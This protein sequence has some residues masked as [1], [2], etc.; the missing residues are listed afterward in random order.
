M[1]YI[2]QSP[3]RKQ[4]AYSA[5]IFQQNLIKGILRVMEEKLKEPIMEIKVPDI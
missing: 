2:R 4:K 1:L 3:N 5:V